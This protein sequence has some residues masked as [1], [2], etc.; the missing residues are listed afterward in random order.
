MTD[1]TRAI[2]V[3][4]PPTWEYLIIALPPFETAASAQGSSDSVATLNREGA[5]GWEALGMTSLADGAVAVLMKRRI[6]A[7]G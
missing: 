2:Q 7:P 5:Q 1:Q 6:A 4:V 3:E